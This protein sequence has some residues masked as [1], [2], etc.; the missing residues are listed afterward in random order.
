LLI[1]LE[2]PDGAGKTT[3]RR[4]LFRGLTEAGHSVFTTWSYSFLDVDAAGVITSARWQGKPHSERELVRAYAQDARLLGERVIGPELAAGATVLLD[5]YLLSFL[6]YNQVLYGI[7]PRRMWTAY[8]AAGVVRPDLTIVVTAPLERCLER[9]NRR[10]RVH[11]WEG[12]QAQAQVHRLYPA[13]L[14]DESLAGCFRPAVML[15]NSGPLTGTLRSIDSL[16]DSLA[17]REA[18]P[19]PVHDIGHP[20]HQLLVD[21]HALRTDV[22]REQQVERPH[23][24]GGRGEG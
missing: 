21:V 9:M 8:R 15:D 3:I 12:A 5:R 16:V 13:L 17:F 6:V 11:R 19:D 24:G 2:G 14:A 20:A 4:H 1:A 10:R 18:V 23:S 22:R 7:D